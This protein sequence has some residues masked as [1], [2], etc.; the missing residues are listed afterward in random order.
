MPAPTTLT[1][2]TGPNR[3]TRGLPPHL[4]DWR[5]PPAWK[6][7]T[8][9]VWG[10]Y[11][12]SQEVIDA[13]G[14]SLALVTAPDASHADWLA[15]EAR[16]LARMDHP[17]APTTYHFWTASHEIPRG[18]GYLRRWIVGESVGAQLERLGRI[19]V[20]S[21]P[22]IIRAAGS[23]LAHM[24]DAGTVHGALSPE[25][26]WI[27]PTGRLWLLGWQWAVT[28]DEIP[29]GL[30]PD[31]RWTPYAP[32]WRR[33]E[34]APT[35]ATDQWQLAATCFAALTGELPPAEAPRLQ[36]VRPEVPSDVAA[37]LD[38]ALSTRPEDRYPSVAALLRS[39]DRTLG[40]RTLV[41]AS[42][43][44]RETPADSSP[45]SEEARLRWA[46][47]DE[48]EVLARL[49]SGTF[50]SVRRVRHLSLKREV[51][52]R[53]L[54]PRV[55]NNDNA[56]RRFRREALL[57][58][59][60]AHP[61]IV[62]VYDWDTNGGVAWYT[63]ELAEGGSLAELIARSGPRPLAEIAPEV[64]HVLDGL[65]AA[66]ASGIVHRDLKPE[67]ILI[68]RYGHWRIA[69]FGV[70]MMAGEDRY[71]P[72][73]TPAFSAPEQILGEPQGPPVDCFALTAIVAFVLS[74]TPPFGE[75]DYRAILARELAGGVDLTR[76]PPEIADWLARG[77]AARPEDRFADAASMRQAWRDAVGPT[78]LYGGRLPWWRR[79]LAGEVEPYRAFGA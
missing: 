13:L 37:V 66:H 38:R 33:C 39:L 23:A 70:A 45:Q 64:D 79:W 59:R 35:P 69:D 48:Y 21:V 10:E 68:D 32:E 28:Q 56:L 8:E 40:S 29:L 7:G 44:R 73:G 20:S 76:Y 31:A 22:G 58:G 15:A 16:R 75:D 53:M 19:D 9:G 14:R 25:T 67:N 1:P 60:L 51:A 30:A 62:P 6:W 71:G 54:N 11:R 55:S 61:A 57:A 4:A 34:W 65:A 49:G 50:G 24:H 52:L 47:G 77:L 3:V 63:M 43:D 26:V 42:T 36:L 74:G 5:L 46:L 27:T 72:T 17:S 12:H 2:L 18:P 41:I 78:L